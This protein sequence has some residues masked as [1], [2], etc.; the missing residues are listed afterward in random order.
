MMEY[1]IK[2]VVIRVAEPKCCKVGMKLGDTF[3]IG[4]L[5]PEPLPICSAAFL[6]LYSL[7][8]ALRFTKSTKLEDA[9]GNHDVVC[10][11]GTVTFRLS[12]MRNGK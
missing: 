1:K 11:D 3:I 10:P 6:A 5:T 8:N 7:T 9:D 4:P 2:C 12:R